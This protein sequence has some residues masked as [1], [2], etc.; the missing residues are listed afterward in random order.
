M[1]TAVRRPRL[2]RRPLAVAFALAGCASA[3]AAALDPGAPQAA[4]NPD[5]IHS[6][7]GAIDLSRFERGN[8]TLPG[9]Y[10]P[11]ILLN[12]EPV[13]GTYDIVFREIAG[14]ESARPCFDRPTLLR[15]GLD[16]EKLEARRVGDIPAHDA[17]CGTLDTIVPGATVDFDES[18]QILRVTLPQAFL[19]SRPRG[20]V[21]PE[22][23]DAGENA[24]MLNYNANTYRIRTQG[25]QSTA[26]YVGVNAGVNLGGWRIRHNGGLAVSAGRRQWRNTLVHAQHDLTDLRAQLTVGETYTA[27]DIL[28]SV[29]IRG[30]GIASDQ[31]MLPA[32]QRG[33]A[34]VIRGVAEGNAQVTV[35]QN[36]YVIHSSTVAPGPFEIDDLYPT[37]YGSDLEVTVTEADGRT[38]TSLVPYT[39]V[40]QMLREG[41]SRF[42]FWAGQV[43]EASVPETPFIAQATMQY[44]ATVNST[45]Y[46]GGTLSNSYAAGLIGAAMNLPFGAVALDVTGSRAATRSGR[47]H[48]GLSTRLRYSR[49]LAATGTS[50]GV[51]AYRFSTR[52]YLGVTDAA[53]LRSRLRRGITGDPVGGERSRFD[54]NLGQTVGTGRLSLTGS[55]VHYWGSR[56]RGLDYTLGYAGSLRSAFYNVSLQR[57]RVGSALGGVFGGRPRGGTDTMLYVSFNVPLGRAAAAPNVGLS[58]NRSNAGD[59]ALTANINGRV[60]GDDDLTYA[61]AASRIETPRRAARNTGSANLAYRGYAGVYRAGVSRSGAGSSQYALGATGAVLA[62]RDG[63]TF[64]QELGETN[65]IVHAPG[66]VGARIESHTGVRLDRHGNAVIRGLQPYQLNHVAIDPRGASHDVHLRS[67]SEAVAPRAGAIARLDYE[68]EQAK[69]VLIHATQPGGDPLPFGASVF[70]EGGKTVGVVGQGSKIFTRGAPAGARLRVSWPGGSCRIALPP[71]LESLPLHGLHRA[72]RSPCEEEAEIAS[73]DDAS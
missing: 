16:T 70:D 10:Q 19:A 22:L 7:G 26:S 33:Y 60:A 48:R 24:A 42:A 62:H 28:D 8:V 17:T 55:V 65:A 52:D 46:A 67:T 2:P 39:A 51:A 58:Y 29:R 5:F 32:S 64:T 3:D 44:G 9:V 68:T 71:S 37:G 15:L 20:Y 50:F 11:H 53:R 69:A 30:L 31:R 12:G 13:P 49:T 45:L 25:R 35:R 54:A 56:S 47:V 34:P 18:E 36:G 4:F 61:L 73:R 57:S 21:A 63:I 59:G 14:S 1:I 40:P 38:K 72:V 43:D 23:W 6:T 41:T 66:A 27:G